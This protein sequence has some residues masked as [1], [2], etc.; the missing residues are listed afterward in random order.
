MLTSRG[1]PNNS[2]DPTG[3]SV[4]FIVNLS[5]DAVVSRRVNSSV[6]FLLNAKA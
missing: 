3:M 1:P 4:S 6:R 2:F 5:H